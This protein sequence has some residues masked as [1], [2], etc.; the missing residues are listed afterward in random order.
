MNSCKLTTSVTLVANAIGE[1]LT[2]DELTLLSAIL[3]QLGDTLAL[4]A[5]SKAICEE[6]ISEKEIK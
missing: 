1:K 6:K 5:T 4:I 3:V 2:I